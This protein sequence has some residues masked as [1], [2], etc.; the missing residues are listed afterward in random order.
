[1]P[2]MPAPTEF[3]TWFK[4]HWRDNK[5]RENMSPK[6]KITKAL[7]RRCLVDVRQL[8]NLPVNE[9]DLRARLDN[10]YIDSDNRR[11]SVLYTLERN[12]PSE[13]RMVYTFFEKKARRCNAAAVA[14]LLHAGYG[15]LCMYTQDK[16][17]TLLRQSL[18]KIFPLRLRAIEQFDPATVLPWPVVQF[19]LHRAID[20]L[21]KADISLADLPDT[22]QAVP[23]LLAPGTYSILQDVQQRELLLIALAEVANAKYSARISH[24]VQEDLLGT[25][26]TIVGIME[27]V[28]ALLTGRL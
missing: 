22:Q 16:I 2:A 10:L 6:D 18:Q 12:L 11:L 23:K 25:T 7:L 28:A 15:S 14:K 19:W 13:P 17:G 24:R 27:N 21:H 20:Q 8:P 1:M 4:L 5:K 3:D 9:R 26:A